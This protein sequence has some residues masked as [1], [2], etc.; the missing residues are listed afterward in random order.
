[1]VEPGGPYWVDTSNIAIAVGVPREVI[2]TCTDQGPLIV[3]WTLATYM[4]LPEERAT[5]WSVPMSIVS[6][7]LASFTEASETGCFVLLSSTWI[8]RVA[9]RVTGGGLGLTCKITE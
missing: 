6:I 7:S 1:W 8:V 9:G 4:P 5:A 3:N 2:V